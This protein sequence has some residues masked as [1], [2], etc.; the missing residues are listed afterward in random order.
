MKPSLSKVYAAM[1]G[2]IDRATIDPCDE[3]EPVPHPIPIETIMPMIKELDA[4]LA[5]WKKSPELVARLTAFRESVQEKPP[6]RLCFDPDILNR[7]GNE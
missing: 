2:L 5:E 6:A 7:H 3:N 4:M 1:G